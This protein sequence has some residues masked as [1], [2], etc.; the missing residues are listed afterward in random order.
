MEPIDLNDLGL[1]DYTLLL[2]KNGS[3]TRNY[4]QTTLQKK[5]EDLEALESSLAPLPTQFERD[6]TRLEMI[7]DCQAPHTQSHSEC[8]RRFVPAVTDVGVCSTFNAPPWS[9]VYRPPLPYMEH[10][11][12]V[13]HANVGGDSGVLHRPEGVGHAHG[14]HL[15]L[16]IHSQGRVSIFFKKDLRKKDLFTENILRFRDYINGESRGFNLKKNTVMTSM[17]A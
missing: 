4:Q 11:A 1:E 5:R 9:Q 14:I 13:Y 16:D 7:V 3:T 2:L 6:F 15:M 12:A 8:L 17:R 10:F